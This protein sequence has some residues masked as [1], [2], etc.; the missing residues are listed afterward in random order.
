MQPSTS[1]LPAPDSAVRMATRPRPQIHV[2]P[3]G[4]PSQLTWVEFLH[5]ANNLTFLTLPALDWCHPTFG[6][7]YGTAITTCQ[8][9]AC[10]EDGYLSTSRDRH[11]HGRIDVDLDSNYTPRDALLPY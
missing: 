6:I 11:A 8:I 1:Q 4:P 3:H 10:N 5:P 7:H 9:L 2:A